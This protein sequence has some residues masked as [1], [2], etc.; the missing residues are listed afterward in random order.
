MNTQLLWV[1]D[2]FKTPY[3]ANGGWNDEKGLYI[4]QNIINNL[5]LEDASNVYDQCCGRGELAMY[6]A[7]EGMNVTGVDQSEDY[8]LHARKINEEN[9]NKFFIADAL[10]WQNNEEFDG[11][12]NWHT[13][14]GYGGESGAIDMIEQLRH[15]VKDGGRY[16]IDIRNKVHYK[17]QNP[18]MTESFLDDNGDKIY[19]Q[20]NGIW[21][22]NILF[23]KWSL[24]KNGA[25]LQENET[26]CFHPSIEW[27]YDIVY[28]VGD[29]V[30]IAQSDF[31]QNYVN[32]ELPRIIFTVKKGKDR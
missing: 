3:V 14:L 28:S 15:Q 2:F 13:S 22:G 20:R 31:E 30:E 24:K 12:I 10:S 7:R 23:Q 29:N 19:I 4:S 9:E 18:V 17:K 27:M 11:A 8:I 21:K 5:Q 6:L 1:H 26:M 25:M 32:N 16:I